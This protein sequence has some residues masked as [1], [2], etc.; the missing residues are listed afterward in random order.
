MDVQKFD[1]RKVLG[2]DRNPAIT[3]TVSTA[4]PFEELLKGFL[5]LVK[6][7]QITPSEYLK[8]L[9]R[10]AEILDRYRGM[11]TRDGL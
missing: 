7:G 6:S 9:D 8:R 1:V 11:G 4:I 10:M 5:G 3:V 2:D